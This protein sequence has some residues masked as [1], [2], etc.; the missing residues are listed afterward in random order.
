MEEREEEDE[1]Q[2]VDQDSPHLLSLL[3][4]RSSRDL[5]VESF[6]TRVFLSLPQHLMAYRRV[7]SAWNIFIKRNVWGRPSSRSYL[8]TKLRRNWCLGVPLGQHVRQLASASATPVQSLA[9][10]DSLLLV[11]LGGQVEVYS[12]L[13]VAWVATLD[14]GQESGQQEEVRLAVAAAFFVTVQTTTRKLQVWTRTSG[15][16]DSMDHWDLSVRCVQARGDQVVLAGKVCQPPAAPV[17]PAAQAGGG[18]M[19]GSRDVLLLYSVEGGKLW[20]R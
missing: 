15:L 6:L 17:T 11:G 7:C 3:L 10:D 13:P 18:W 9:C 14:L 4:L 2:K 20:H 8:Q 16:L 12:L 5:A 19:F 1:Q